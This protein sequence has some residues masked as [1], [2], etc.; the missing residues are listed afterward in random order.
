[1]ESRS[2]IVVTDPN[3]AA[4]TELALRGAT[5]S[6]G[7]LAELNEVAL[8]PDPEQ[9]VTRQAHCRLE[10]E[11]MRWFVVDGGSVN[12]TF[13]RRGGELQQVVRRT[14]LNDGDI[15]C[16]LGSLAGG[17]RRYFEITYRGTA[18]SQATLAA[19]MSA[20]C[21]TYDSTAARLVLVAGRDRHEIEIRAQAHRLVRHM[22]ERNAAAGEPAL[23]TADELMRAVW[24]DE[25]FH[26]RVELA[27]LFWE[28]RKKLEPFGAGD[29]IENERRVGYRL[30]TCA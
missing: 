13:L 6:I 23:C 22:A 9:L 29:L 11:G 26:S 16:V 18:D 30:R 7:R 3:G 5:V 25:P 8:Q 15:V 21:L 17:T 1:M 10:R 28:L 24:G 12:G 4:L 19:P 27:R 14:M 20:A 2:S